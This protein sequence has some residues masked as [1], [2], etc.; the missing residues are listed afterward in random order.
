MMA[1]LESGLKVASRGIP[2]LFWKPCNR[3]VTIINIFC[4][5]LNVPF[6]QLI[7]GHIRMVPA[8]IRGC[9]KVLSHCRHICMVTLFWQ[10]VKL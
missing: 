6:F 10:Q 7:L 9:D 5:G 3:K 8:Y 4:I 2:L 1:N